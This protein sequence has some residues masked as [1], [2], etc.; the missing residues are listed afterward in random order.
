MYLY[1]KMAKNPDELIDGL[2]VGAYAAKVSSPIVLANSKLSDKQVKALENK[3]IS[4]ITQVG[5]GPNSMAVTEL[6]IMKAGIHTDIDTKGTNSDN[7]QLD[8]SKI[9]SLEVNSKTVKNFEQK[10]NN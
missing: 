6:L 7:S 4:N 5:L 8:S 10:E 2:A 9:D 1:Q 3:K